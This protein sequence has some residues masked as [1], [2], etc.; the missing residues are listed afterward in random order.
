MAR[1]L[2]T[3]KRRIGPAPRLGHAITFDQTRTRTVLFG[4]ADSTQHVFGDT[5]EWD[6]EHWTQLDDIGPT[7]RWRHGLAYDNSRRQVVLFGGQGAGAVPTPLADSWEWD[8]E[9]WTQIANGGPPPRHSHAMAFDSTRNRTLLFGGSSPNG[10]LGDTWEWDGEEWVQVEDAGPPARLDHAMAFDTARGRVVL[11][12]GRASDVFGDTWEWDGTV[13]TQRSAIGPPPATAVAMAATG[14]R[15]LVFGGLPSMEDGA[16]PM[17][18]TW[19]WDGRHW[20]I[21]QDVG[22]GPRWDHAMAYDTVRR[23]TVLFGGAATAPGQPFGPLGDTWEQ[24]ERGATAPP[25]PPTPPPGPAPVPPTLQSLTIPPAVDEGR[26][27]TIEVMLAGPAAEAATIQIAV[28][29]SA[30]DTDVEFEIP[31]AAGASAATSPMSG[32]FPG[33]YTFAARLGTGTRTAPIEVRTQTALTLTELRLIP[34][35]I[36]VG[37]PFEIHVTLSGPVTGGELFVPTRASLG[38]GPDR[39]FRPVPVP[40]GATAG[41]VTIEAFAPPVAPVTIT[42]TF[43]GAV[44]SAVLNFGA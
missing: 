3:Q 32:L 35:L 5:W 23:R 42:G 12:G 20:T 17:G 1:L 8:G 7:P 41:T 27:F 14:T 36:F 22:P 43:G 28:T 13:W 10:F 39:F 21:R 37:Q 38:P 29:D 44:R 11:F 4:G 33:T 15:V 34:G 16:I 26:T 31:V 40:V 25:P 30:G 6:G 2:W 18:N 24:F 9:A 19:E